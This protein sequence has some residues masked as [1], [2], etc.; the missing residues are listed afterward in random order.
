M[1]FYF[2]FQ[3]LGIA[4]GVE[5][6][7]KAAELLLKTVSFTGF[8]GGKISKMSDFNLN[9]PIANFGIAISPTDGLFVSIP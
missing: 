1:I 3:F 7:K 9:F 4:G 2:Y 5:A 6:I 8:N